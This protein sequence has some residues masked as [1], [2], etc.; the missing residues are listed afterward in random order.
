MLD[1]VAIVTAVSGLNHITSYGLHF[2]FFCQWD[3]LVGMKT[4]DGADSDIFYEG[5][6]Q[7]VG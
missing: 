2:A 5:Q 6:A 4:P 7:G 3:C 1:V